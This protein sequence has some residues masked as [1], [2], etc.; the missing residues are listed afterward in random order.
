M[1][2]I[3]TQICSNPECKKELS[4]SEFYKNKGRPNGLQGYCKVCSNEAKKNSRKNNPKIH[5]ENQKRQRLKREY[6]LT[7]EQYDDIFIE[8][9]SECLI[10]GVFYKNTKKGL[11]ID[12]NHDTGEIRGLLCYKCNMGIGYFND[13]PK[14][15]IKASNYLLKIHQVLCQ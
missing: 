12:H 14:L 15:L 8:Q 9:G 6:N 5:R 7:P 11:F 2:V 3:R 10:C 1:S 4:L 13:D